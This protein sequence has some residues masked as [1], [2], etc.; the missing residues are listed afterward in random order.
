M[1]KLTYVSSNAGKAAY[2]AR[3]LNHPFTHRVLELDEIQSLD[4]AKITE[5]KAREAYARLKKPV[6]VDDVSLSFDALGGTLPGPFIKWFLRALKPEGMCRLLDGYNDRGAVGKICMTYFD[7][8]TLKCF[9]GS[10]KGTIA[11]QPRKGIRGYGW[12]VIFIPNGSNKTYSE[13]TDAEIR[14]YGIRTV[15]IFPQLK[16]FLKSQA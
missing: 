10:L 16:K 6:L 14:K 15:K 12:D 1:N 4:L 9:E 2:L 13:M 5:H 3:Y 7:G 8:S 11:K